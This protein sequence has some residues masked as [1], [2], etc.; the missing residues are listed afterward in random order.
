MPAILTEAPEN[1]DTEVE[2]SW[3]LFCVT[4]EVAENPTVI[5]SLN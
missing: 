3:R 5:Y 4:P 2:V 1:R